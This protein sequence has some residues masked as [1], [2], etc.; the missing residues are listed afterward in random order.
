M[1]VMCRKCEDE[2]EP[3]ILIA[4]GA[5]YWP[6]HCPFDEKMKPDWIDMGN[7]GKKKKDPSL[8]VGQALIDE[9]NI[10]AEDRR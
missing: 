9:R 2:G 5:D 4:V 1:K 8:E 10:Q 3:C 6:F 7:C